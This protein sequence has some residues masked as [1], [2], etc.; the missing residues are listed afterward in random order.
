MNNLLID[1]PFLSPINDINTD[2]TKKEYKA[3]VDAEPEYINN[4]YRQLNKNLEFNYGDIFMIFSF[5]EQISNTID[6]EYSEYEIIPFHI[7]LNSDNYLWCNF[8]SPNTLLNKIDKSN[9]R[10]ISYELILDDQI[11]DNHNFNHSV[12][13][14]FDSKLKISYIFDSNGDFN[15]FDNHKLNSCLKSY[16]ELLEYHF[17][18]IRNVTN[19]KINVDVSINQKSFIKGYCRSWTF[20]FQYILSNC[21]DNFQFIEFINDLCKNDITILT[22][23][24]EKFTIYLSTTMKPSYYS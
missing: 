12:L 20:L 14:I 10:Y 19:I 11:M 15:Y 3:V 7:T 4:Y 24:I 21:S 6:V 2:L 16:S 8:M 13:F 5:N 1:L 18:D 9:L 22:K 17:I 23:L